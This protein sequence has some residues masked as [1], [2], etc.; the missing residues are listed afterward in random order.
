M[1]GILTIAVEAEHNALETLLV[2][3][4]PADICRLAKTCRSLHAAISRSLSSAFQLDQRLLSFFDDPHLFRAL[5]SRTGAIISGSFAL[6]FFTRMSFGNDDLDVYVA[7]SARGEV[8]S[9][10]LS[11]GYHFVARGPILHPDTGTV[12]HPGQHRDY[13]IALDLFHNVEVRG[14]RLVNGVVSIMDFYRSVGGITRKVQVH[15]VMACPLYTILKSHSS[16]S[17]HSGCTL[18]F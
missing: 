13:N 3:L 11:Q 17:H 8:G 2:H 4:A 15:L 14:R 9:W 12:I 1:S 7:A 10:L 6:K 5:Q 18:T 16:M